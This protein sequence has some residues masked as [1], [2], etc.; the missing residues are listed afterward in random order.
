MSSSTPPNIQGPF[1]ADS[2][3]Y[4]V[5]G[6]K[7]LVVPKPLN[8]MLS[9]VV[10]VFTS[11]C[12][13]MLLPDVFVVIAPSCSNSAYFESTDNQRVK[14]SLPKRYLSDSLGNMSLSTSAVNTTLSSTLSPT[15]ILPSVPALKYAFPSTLISP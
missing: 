5:I 15:M 9:F 4:V 1:I 13:K 8:V 3:L 11:K 7:I 6:V 12:P 10:G 2:W 14:S